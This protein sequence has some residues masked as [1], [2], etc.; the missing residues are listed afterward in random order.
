L[1]AIFA[2]PFL[3]DLGESRCVLESDVPEEWEKAAFAAF[4]FDPYIQNI[5]LDIFTMPSFEI[6]YFF[7]NDLV[8]GDYSRQRA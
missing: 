8:R 2:K 4:F 6:Y 3:G 5:K 7:W 1:A